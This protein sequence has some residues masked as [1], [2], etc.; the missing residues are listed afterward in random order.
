MKRIK[1]VIKSLWKIV[2]QPEMAHLPGH[3]AFFLV[4][5][6]FPILTLIGVI[7]S[8]FNISINNLVNLINE[9]LPSNVTQVIIP[10]IQGK[11]FD[12]N[13]FVFMVVGF[14]LASNGA[15]A[16]TLASNSLY[17]F[18]NNSY[19]RRRIKAFFMIVLMIFLFVFLLAFLAFGNQIFKFIVGLISVEHIDNFLF[20]IFAILKW[21]FA[22]FIIFFNVKL[23]YTIAPDEVVLSKTTTKGA[24]FTTVCW[25]V[26][27]ALF[28]LYVKLMGHYDL[29]YGSMA[30]I[31]V[32]MLW[33]YMLSFIFVIGIALNVKTMNKK[34]NLKD[35]NK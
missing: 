10:Y 1:R 18:E 23:L 6:V 17:K 22:M 25:T 24:F 7:A 14:F 3:L 28:T 5:S 31:I 29:F 2:M 11:G 21:P 16:I 35:N 26:A 4:L 19:I 32:V 12:D 20:L 15:H 27:T 33:I 30:N 13:V 9:S 8:F 34:E